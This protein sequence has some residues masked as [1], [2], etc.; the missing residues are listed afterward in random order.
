MQARLLSCCTTLLLLTSFQAV[1]GSDKAEL[2]RPAGEGAIEV[3]V[4]GLASVEGIL[5]VSL[6]LTAEGYPGEWQRAYSTQQLPAQTA[7]DGT[8]LVRF[9]SVP[10]GWFV[11]SVL[12]DADSNN[13]MATNALGIPKEG[14]GF[15]NNPKSFFGPPGFD[16]AAVYLEPGE[17]KQVL[18]TI[19]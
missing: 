8:M 10:A 12:H 6:Y 4:E 3:R 7:V 1:A 11:I 17:T 16:K 14:Y 9:E 15:S 19:K 5:F 18:V 2:E 13:E